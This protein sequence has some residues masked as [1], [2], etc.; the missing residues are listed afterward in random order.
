MTY[1]FTPR[2]R[3]GRRRGDGRTHETREIITQ[4]N[5]ISRRRGGSW[6]GAGTRA[7]RS[8]GPSTPR[9]MEIQT[10]IRNLKGYRAEVLRK[11]QA[12]MVDVGT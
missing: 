9:S 11:I 1:T 8:S 4:W 6:R 12:E 5:L 10:E 2:C 3:P 7:R